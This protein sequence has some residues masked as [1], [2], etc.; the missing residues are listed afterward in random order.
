MEKI[1]IIKEKLQKL[2]NLDKRYSIFGA[3][4]HKYQ[5]KS[6]LSEQEISKIEKE[7]G[8]FISK[9]YKEILKNLAN[10]G[11][12]CGY[13]LEPLTLNKINPPYIGTKQLLRNCENPQEID[14]DMVDIDEIS[15]Y[16]KLFDYGCGME[17][18]LIVNGE[19]K[20]DL[21]FFDCDGRFEKMETKGILEI[22]ENWLNESLLT[23]TR[24][25][26][27]LK[28]MNNVQDVID[29]EWALK[30]FSIREMVFSI[31]NRINDKWCYS[32]RFK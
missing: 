32:K 4:R 26:N 29:N 28:E 5:L 3:S 12:G 11:A 27:K 20:G 6:T 1:K 23:L 15:G 16:I 14:L 17:T 9:E 24:V 2:K 10:G 13:G 8:I 19:E 30:N 31:I 22:Y 7:N 21:I 25:E 18:C